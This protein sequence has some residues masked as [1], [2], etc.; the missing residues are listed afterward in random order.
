[1]DV[2]RG[3]G[4]SDETIAALRA[5]IAEET[6][7]RRPFYAWKIRAEGREWLTLSDLEAE[8]WDS[9]DAGQVTIVAWGYDGL[10]G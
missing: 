9:T 4:I 3:K 10:R 1:M 7:G 5:V 6:D 8:R 2:G